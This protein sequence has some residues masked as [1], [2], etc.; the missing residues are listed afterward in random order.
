MDSRYMSKF[1]PSCTYTYSFSLST[2]E[3]SG[4]SFRVSASALLTSERVNSSL[5]S[6]M[7]SFT[8]SSRT[9][10]SLRTIV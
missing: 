4:K 8:R 2:I 10:L 7:L 1:K 3:F 6:G 5:V 9:S